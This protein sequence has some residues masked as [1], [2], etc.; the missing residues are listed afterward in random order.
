[1]S[2]QST[3]GPRAQQEI[4]DAWNAKHPIG[5]PVTRYKL[6][7]PLAEPV[8]TLTRSEAWLMGGH[9][10]MVMVEGQAGGVMVESCKPRRTQ[11][12]PAVAWPF[13]KPED[14]VDQA[15]QP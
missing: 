3:K 15:Q 5:T 2:G 1:M 12:N 10:A 11:L 7:N 8:E 6:I 4:V 13:P 9:T 14:L